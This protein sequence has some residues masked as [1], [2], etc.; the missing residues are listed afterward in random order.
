MPGSFP[1]AALLR[2]RQTQEDQAAGQLARAALELDAVRA[3]RS[4][5]RSSMAASPSEVHSSE[6]MMA[7]V[8]ARAA[9]R[10][11][12]ADLDALEADTDAAHAAAATTYAIARSRT[13][14]LD[15]MGERHAAQ[16]LASE[17]KT[18]QDALD[19]ITTSPTM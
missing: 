16:S 7:L 15:R 10:S 13:K 12:L 2:L 18:E 8:A 6:Q 5:A 19:E 1:L 9:G 4:S 17:L 11:M 3:R 14:P